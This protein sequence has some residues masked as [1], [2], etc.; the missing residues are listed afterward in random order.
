MTL[1]AVF[2]SVRLCVRGFLF[3]GRLRLAKRQNVCY[4]PAELQIFILRRPILSHAH[5][6]IAYSL[7]LY[8]QKGGIPFRR[9][10][11]FARSCE[12]N[13]VFCHLVAYC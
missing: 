2:L 6:H 13:T 8:V 11:H 10:F 1:T 3:G 5:K 4:V 9:R 7:R 12:G